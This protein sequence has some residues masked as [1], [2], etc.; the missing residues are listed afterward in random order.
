MAAALQ[1]V[2]G[3]IIKWMNDIL[4]GMPI[5]FVFRWFDSSYRS[6]VGLVF[7]W[8]LNPENSNARLSLFSH[9]KNPSKIVFPQLDYAYNLESKFKPKKKPSNENI[10]DKQM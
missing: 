9:K 5:D 10:H 4:N 3:G 8:A 6:F 2:F 1:S 7:S